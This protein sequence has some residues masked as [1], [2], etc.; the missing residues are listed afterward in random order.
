MQRS[1]VRPFGRRQ[2]SEHGAVAIMVALL[3]AGLLVAAAMVVDLGWCVS[4]A[5]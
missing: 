2:R 1:S 3:M 5:R 4:I